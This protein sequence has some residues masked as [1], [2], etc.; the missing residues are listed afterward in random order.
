[1][2]LFVGVKR[3]LYFSGRLVKLRRGAGLFGLSQGAL[4]SPDD[5][6]ERQSDVGYRCFVGQ[7]RFI[8]LIANRNG[9]PAGEFEAILQI[10]QGIRHWERLCDGQTNEQVG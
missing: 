2:N 7:S 1:M 10:I 3:D 4:V 8:G 9:S 5:H 6:S